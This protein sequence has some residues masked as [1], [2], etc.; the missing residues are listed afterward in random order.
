MEAASSAETRAWRM[1]KEKRVLSTLA[2][3]FSGR[4]DATPRRTPC[5]K[6]EGGGRSLTL[7]RL[8]GD[9]AGEGDA[10]A[11]KLEASDG[12][13]EEEHGAEDEED[14]LDDTCEREGQGA[15][16]AD[17][18]DGGDVEAK[19][20]ASVCEEDEGAEVGDLEERQETLGE[21][22]HAGVDGGADGRKVVERDEGVHLEALEEHLD[23]D[24]T[25]GLK[26]DGEHLADEAGHGKVA[27]TV[28]G[29]CDTKGDAADDH[30]EGAGELL[31]AEG[32][33][34][35]QD[36]D[37]GEG[38][39]HLDEAD[40]EGESEEQKA[41]EGGQKEAAVKIACL[42]RYSLVVDDN[43]TGE[44]DPEDDDDGGVDLLLVVLGRATGEDAAGGLCAHTAVTGGAHG[45]GAVAG[46]G[47]V[48]GLLVDREALHGERG[49]IL[50][51]GCD[52]WSWRSWC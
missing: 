13:A 24:E 15:S 52:G 14:V 18:E 8:E 34:D 38:L 23:H 5:Q 45:G 51:H 42:R 25:R 33:R 21:G 29:E 39:E 20:D 1:Q 49:V 37:G 6:G 46:D 9:K 44:S 10:V 48:A 27:L 17:E 28:G 11:D 47:V 36:G 12:V 3:L 50:G 43:A 22:K 35:E 32:E 16:G 4:A 26:G 30:G 40:A 41:E 31:E 7:V 2:V 19:G